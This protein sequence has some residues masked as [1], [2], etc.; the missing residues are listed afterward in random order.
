[1][2]RKIICADSLKWLKNQTNNSIDNF[3][4]GIADM[5][6]VNMNID[7]YKIFIDDI[8]TLI[9][10]TLSDD[11]YA[12][13]IQTDRKYE[14]SWIDK[15]YLISRIADNFGLKMIWHKILL[16]RD[17][18]ATDLYR[19][20]YSH[21]LCYSK[22][23]TTGSATP[24]VLPISKRLYKNSTP[25]L[26]A[27]R[28][29]EFILKYSKGKLIVD[30]F[31]GRGTICAICDL[32]GVPSIGIDISKSQCKIAN[33]FIFSKSD[34]DYINNMTNIDKSSDK[35]DKP[36]KIDKH[37]NNI[38]SR[39]NRTSRTRKTSKHKI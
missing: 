15:S 17:V 22:N 29:V 13:F 27:L 12:I 18:N 31:V 9:F 24:D 5:D 8:L 21:M 37:K 34:L 7:K 3:V 36:D 26:P 33:D 4:T 11:G 1:M 38:T 32:F 23:G 39:T 14:R 10:K 2:I 19:P 25:L 6:E 20:T 30:P 35:P 16:N 28:A